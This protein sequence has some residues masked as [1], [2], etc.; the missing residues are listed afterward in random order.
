MYLTTEQKFAIVQQAYTFPRNIL[1][2][3]MMSTTPQQP[4]NL[5]D[6]RKVAED[7]GIEDALKAFFTIERSFTEQLRHREH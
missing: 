5:R 4:Q 3:G 7:A 2:V 6:H 1:N